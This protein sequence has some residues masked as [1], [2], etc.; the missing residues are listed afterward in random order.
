LTVHIKHGLFFESGRNPTAD[1]TNRL[2][3]AEQ[4]SFWTATSLP[5]LGSSNHSQLASISDITRKLKA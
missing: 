1:W 5:M 3:F 2:R 4:D